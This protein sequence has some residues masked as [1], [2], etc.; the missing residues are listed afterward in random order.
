MSD[1]EFGTLSNSEEQ[2]FKKLQASAGNAKISH[3]KLEEI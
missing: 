1:F 2:K 3:I